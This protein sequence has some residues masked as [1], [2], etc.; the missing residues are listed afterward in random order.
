MVRDFSFKVRFGVDEP[1]RAFPMQS[2]LAGLLNESSE[3][4]RN[5]GR[6]S[7]AES[8]LVALRDKIQAALNEDTK[9]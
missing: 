5:V 4:G 6:L 9:R 3:T 1:F 2:E 7:D 8:L